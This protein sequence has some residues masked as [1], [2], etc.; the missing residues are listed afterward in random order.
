MRRALLALV[1]LALPLGLATARA[2]QV[3]DFG[4]EAR[5]LAATEWHQDARLVSIQVGGYGFDT[6][7]MP[8]TPDNT[9]KIVNFWFYSPTAGKDDILNVSRQFNFPPEM[10][11]VLK[12]RPEAATMR[13]REME[14]YS[15]VIPWQIDIPAG[16][17]DVTDAVALAQKSALSEDCAG[18]NPAYGCAHVALAELHMYIVGDRQA[19]PVW[20]VAFGQ[21]KSARRVARLIN[22]SSRKLITNCTVPDLSEPATARTNLYLDCR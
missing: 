14:R 17:M 18:T 2:D 15:S 12:L 6:S 22:A 11:D 19:L 13:R 10:K 16:I 4:R 8:P 5:T 7:K 3:A 1:L 21:D 9:P 20:K